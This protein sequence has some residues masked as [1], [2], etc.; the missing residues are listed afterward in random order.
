MFLILLALP[1]L[2]LQVL[3][4]LDVKFLGAGD[5]GAPFWGFGCDILE[6]LGK[7]ENL[8]PPTCA[9]TM[10]KHAVLE[11]DTVLCTICYTTTGPQELRSG[12]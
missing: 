11:Y 8:D 6:K 5:L 7:L 10:P 12:L 9:P 1:A 2:G 4:L 3:T